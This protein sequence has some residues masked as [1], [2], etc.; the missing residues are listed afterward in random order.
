MTGLGAV[1]WAA[2]S[3][4]LGVVQTAIVLVTVRVGLAQLRDGRRAAQFTATRG[5]VAHALDPHFHQ[6]LQVVEDELA[7]RLANPTYAREIA[8]SRGWDVDAARHPEL[9]VLARLEEIGTYVKYHLVAEDALFDYLGELVVSSWERLGD[10]VRIMRASHRNP[11][12]WANA[13]FV[14]GRARDWLA[15]ERAPRNASRSAG[16]RMPTDRLPPRSSG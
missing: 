14:Y 6:A 2:V 1:D 5:L 16:R 4:G 7:E 12:V 11:R 10:V 13:E 8:A 9:L 15:R 3:A